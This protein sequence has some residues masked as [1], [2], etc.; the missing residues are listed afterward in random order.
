MD[1]SRRSFLALLAGAAVAPVI[2][3]SV[4]TETLKWPPV[5]AQVVLRCGTLV[6]VFEGSWFDV[7]AVDM[8]FGGTWEHEAVDVKVAPGDG[9]TVKRT[10]MRCTGAMKQPTYSPY[11]VDVWSSKP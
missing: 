10:V 3:A 1:T 2:P 6:P 8:V 4:P 7:A 9:D 5:C 11:L